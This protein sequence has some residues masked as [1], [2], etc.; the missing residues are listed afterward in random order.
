MK[1]I[2]I[3]S[4][5][6]RGL[7][8]RLGMARDDL[9][10]NR[11]QLSSVIQDNWIM[12]FLGPMMLRPGYGYIAATE[13][14]NAAFHIPFIFSNT[15]TAIIE[16]TDALMRAYVS[17]T[18]ITR[19]SVSTAVSNGTFGSDVTGWDDEDETGAASEFEGGGY[20][21]LLGTGYNAAVR[22]QEVTV[23]GGDQNVEHALRIIVTR[24]VVT[25]RVGSTSGDDDYVSATLT[26][27]THSLAFTPTGN[28]HIQV[29]SKTEYKT[30]IDSI[31]IE[32]SGDMT[33]VAPWAGAD[34]SLLRYEQSADVIYVWCSGYQQYKIERRATNSWS[35]V[36]YQ[37]DDGPWRVINLTTTSLTPSALTG[38]ITVTSSA[39][40]F[41]SGNVGGL[42]KITSIGQMVSLTLTG[43]NQFSDP[44]RVVGVDESRIFNIDVDVD[45]SW[46]TGIVTI[47]R[48]VGE[49][50]DWVDTSLAYTAD[51]ST[52]HDDG[53]DNQI[54]YYRIGVKTGDY[55]AGTAAVSLSYESGGLTG[56]VRVVSFNSDTSVDAIVLKPLGSTEGSTD[57]YEGE[58]STRR[59]HPSSGALNEGRLFHGGKGKV[60]G[61]AS[62]A[63]ESFDDDIVGD[64]G[65]ISRTIGRGPVDVIQWLVSSQRLVIGG[66]GSEWV[67][68]SS[69]FDEPLTPTNFTLKDPSNQ[70]SAAV[71]AL[72]VDSTVMFVQKSGKRLFL[73][74][75]S[76]ETNDYKSDDITSL[77]PELTSSGIVRLGL[78][79]QPDTRVHCVLNDGTA[80]I[81]IF[82]ALDGSKGWLRVRTD[83]SIEDVVVLPGTTEDAVYYVVKRTIDGST[84]RYLERWAMETECSGGTYVYNSTSSTAIPN[85]TQQAS[86]ELLPYSDGTVV[87]A[88]DSAGDK[89]ENLTV[90]NGIVTLSTAAT[91]VTLTPSVYKLADSHVTYSGSATTTITAAHLA[92]EEVVVWGDGIDQGTVTLNGSGI[93]TISNSVETYCAGL[94]YKARYKSTKLSVVDRSNSSLTQ[95][96]NL[97]YLGII[98]A[99]THCQ[100][101][102]YGADFDN[103]DPLP[104]DDIPPLGGT[105]TT[106]DTNH[107]WIEY[108]QEAFELDGV[109]ATDSRL[110]LTADAPRPAN[111]LAAVIGLRVEEKSGRDDG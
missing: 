94:T 17:E 95:V 68:R 7:L 76:F 49:P 42:F 31:S 88:R 6:N 79:R 111:V 30:L 51:Q 15:D 20:M 96:K 4:P 23:A 34:L 56:V 66:Q 11:Y 105:G 108:D 60:W 45:G 53:L 110:V 8:S 29:S 48:S 55:V 58:W 67:A 71:Q 109:W 1:H 19:P 47:Q 38:D 70:G 63:Y 74:T 82:N 83:G 98:M 57:W 90:T 64:S 81:M 21:Y 61:S 10:D 2:T 86:G 65:P 106:A 89:I 107:V 27:G 93:G 14:N 73:A 50:G 33:I 39:P 84:V 59:G 104:L 46:S 92:N 43:E 102:Q 87:T 78:Q 69:S 54:I 97:N 25:L 99:D 16:I 40:A 72:K 22:H 85:A 62:D 3:K 5:M 103:L 52:T 41:T 32:A 75:Y 36:K 13:S 18:I 12:R 80:G 37:P 44:I 26:E 101:I 28:F 9:P 24:G 100:G 77:V 91:Y 35:I